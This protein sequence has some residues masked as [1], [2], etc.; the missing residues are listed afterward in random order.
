MI[1]FRLSQIQMMVICPSDNDLPLLTE[2]VNRGGGEAGGMER[3][4]L[5][6]NAE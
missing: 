6:Q 1:S 4:C 2:E 5:P 3:S